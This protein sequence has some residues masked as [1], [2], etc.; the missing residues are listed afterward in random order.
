MKVFTVSE[1]WK[2]T[3]PGA[4]DGILIMHEVVNPQ[5]HPALDQRKEELE[6]DLRSRYAGYDRTGLE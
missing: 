6:R 2:T 5:R 1:E 3:Y 4:A